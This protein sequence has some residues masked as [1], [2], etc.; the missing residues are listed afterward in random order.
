MLSSSPH[1]S[2]QRRQ[3]L[4]FAV[5][6]ANDEGDADPRSRRKD[7]R[8]T[9]IYITTATAD[10][11]VLVLYVVLVVLSRRIDRSGPN[12]RGSRYYDE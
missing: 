11:T 6:A 8:T 1:L 9:I 4:C 5:C 7:K 2:S 10:V 12:D 3:R